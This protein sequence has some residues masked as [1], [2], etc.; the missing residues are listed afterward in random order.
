MYGANLSA[1]PASQECPDEM[2]QKRVRMDNIDRAQLLADLEQ[3]R[4]RVAADGGAHYRHAEAGKLR[5]GL[6]VRLQ[7]D[8]DVLQPLGLVELHQL[9][10]DRADAALGPV[11]DVRN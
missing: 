11:N 2:G 7:Q 9:A 5:R 8:D 3:R 1:A 10:D 6:A 4:Q